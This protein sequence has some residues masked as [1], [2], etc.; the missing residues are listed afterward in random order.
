MLKKL[1]IPMF[2]LAGMLAFVAPQPAKAGGVHFGVTVGNP[3]Y[4]YPAPYYDG[5][6]T[7][8]AYSY[9]YPTYPY[10]FYSAP[11]WGGHEHHEHYEHHRE[12][13]GEAHRSGHEGHGGEY[14]GR[15]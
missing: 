12:Y 2:A 15:H 7:P 5:Y 11:F 8:Y 4:E 9:G 13:R 3:Y 14:H 6:P 1:G 10:S